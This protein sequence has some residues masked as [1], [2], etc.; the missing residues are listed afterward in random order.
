[1]ATINPYLKFNGVC[2]PAFNFYQSVFGGAFT[3]K[4]R[5]GDMPADI[6]R[7]YS[8]VEASKIMHVSL[9]IGEGS[10]LMGCDIPEILGTG[11][12][13]NCFA[14]CITAANEAEADK[15][16]NGLSAGGAVEMPLSK[17]FWGAYFGMCTD[18][19]GVEWMVDCQL[20]Q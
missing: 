13:G 2:E 9:P 16:F 19:F 15:L 1:M 14:V 8:A 4:M 3:T 5:F 17:T 6:P 7:Q 12:Q 11:V 10:V 20:S 18:K